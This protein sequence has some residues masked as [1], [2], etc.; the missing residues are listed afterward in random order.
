MSSTRSIAALNVAALA[1]VV[2]FATAHSVRA[3]ALPSA[4]VLLD[5]TP[6]PTDGQIKQA[7]DGILCRCATYLRV[8][9]AVKRAATMK[10]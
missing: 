7:L 9:R 8:L 5:R 2:L 3:Q 6:N 10:A 1:V 4:K